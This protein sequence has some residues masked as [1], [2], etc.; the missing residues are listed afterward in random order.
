MPSI[1]NFTN[2]LGE[3]SP[4][5]RTCNLTTAY[6]TNEIYASAGNW[7]NIYSFYSMLKINVD[8]NYTDMDD[9]STDLL[10]SIAVSDWESISFDSARL[11]Y[12]FFLQTN[13]SENPNSGVV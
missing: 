9:K 1:L 13:A 11:I 6:L 3:L 10:Y 4:L 12:L 7:V 8:Q 5:A 2:A